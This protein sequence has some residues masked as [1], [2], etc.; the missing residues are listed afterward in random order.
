M[1]PRGT[2]VT[3]LPLRRKN[4][5]LSSQ[6]RSRDPCMHRAPQGQC[7]APDLCVWLRRAEAQAGAFCTTDRGFSCACLKAELAG[8]GSIV[9]A[10][11]RK[12]GRWDG[13]G[14]MT[15]LSC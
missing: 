9:K 5:R 8:K 15:R 13:A 1:S 2:R 6:A 10:L 3:G 14:A 12:A 4:R 7:C 11:V